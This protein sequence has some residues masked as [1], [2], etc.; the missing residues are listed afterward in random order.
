MTLRPLFD[1]VIVEQHGASEKIAGSNLFAA[2]SSK[3]KPRT[4]TVVAVGEGL[5]LNDGSIKKIP[6]SVGDRVVFSP[7]GG[8]EIDHDGKTYL[9]M[10]AN[11]VLAVV[12]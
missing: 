9:I 4:G 12:G 11:E 5:L 7:Y 1:K 2:E 8:T 10:A 6:L 3:E